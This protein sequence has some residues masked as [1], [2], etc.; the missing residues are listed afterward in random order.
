MKASLEVKPMLIGYMG[1]LSPGQFLMLSSLH[2]QIIGMGSNRC[3]LPTLWET[4]GNQDN[5]SGAHAPIINGAQPFI[6]TSVT[7]W[8]WL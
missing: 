1:A 7:S 4:L 6:R 8:G 3:Y 2:H 5:S